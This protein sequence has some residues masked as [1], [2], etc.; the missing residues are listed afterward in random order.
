M[1]ADLAI[2]VK[3]DSFEVGLVTARG[4]DARVSEANRVVRL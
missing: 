3:D 4:S 1:P 2:E